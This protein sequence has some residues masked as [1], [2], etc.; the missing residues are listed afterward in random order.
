MGKLEDLES[1][2]HQVLEKLT[3]LQQENIKLRAECD[4]LKSHLGLVGGENNKAQQVLAKY[5]QLRKNRE[6][7]AHRVERALTALNSLRTA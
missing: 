3:A 1:R 2:V 4:S 6:Q 7:V 5:E